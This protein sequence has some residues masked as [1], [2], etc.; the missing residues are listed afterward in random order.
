M[1]LVAFPA[2]GDHA[3][4]LPIMSRW[5][6]HLRV[7]CDGF[8]G[9]FCSRWPLH[10]LLFSWRVICCQYLQ[11]WKSLLDIFVSPS[12]ACLNYI[13][14]ISPSSV[15][16][17]ISEI[18]RILFS[19]ELARLKFAV[20]V[21]FVFRIGS[22]FLCLFLFLFYSLVDPVPFRFLMTPCRLFSCF[23]W[24]NPIRWQLKLLAGALVSIFLF[25][26]NLSHVYWC[27][28]GRSHMD[29]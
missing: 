10:I 29:V 8:C 12:L 11:V 18:A 7:F 17:N 6:T 21:I 13:E 24:S 1:W 3:P 28:T 20:L 23:V 5:L 27:G 4:P 9:W 14:M 26:F 2:Q 25:S 19:C 16:L 22:K 15:C